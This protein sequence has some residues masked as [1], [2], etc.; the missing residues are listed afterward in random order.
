MST[1]TTIHETVSDVQ[2]A[3][4]R[5][6]YIPVGTDNEDAHHVYR[7]TDESVHVIKDGERTVRYDLEEL[8]KSIN[9]W[10]DYVYARREGFEVQHLYK[11]LNSAVTGTLGGVA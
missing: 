6:D 3:D 11:N 10:I 1:T 4:P 2:P 9:N 5:D 7:T 8:E